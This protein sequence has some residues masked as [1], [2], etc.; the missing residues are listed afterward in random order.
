MMHQAEQTLMWALYW[1][2]CANALFSFSAFG[3]LTM[4]RSDPW[5]GWWDPERGF[6]S[7]RKTKLGYSQ[8]C[9]AGTNFNTDRLFDEVTVYCTKAYY[10]SRVLSLCLSTQSRA[11]EK[12]KNLKEIK[13]QNNHLLMKKSNL[14]LVLLNKQTKKQFFCTFRW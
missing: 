12:N 4:N 1:H 11:W 10:L 14:F 13:K 3:M 6:L 2:G 5:Q 9:Q 8:G 7:G